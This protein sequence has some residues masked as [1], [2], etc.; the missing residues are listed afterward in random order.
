MLVKIDA[1]EL[2]CVRER[3]CNPLDP[4]AMARVLTGAAPGEVRGPLPAQLGAPF[5]SVH[6]RELRRPF[7]PRDVL[8]GIAAVAVEDHACALLR[9]QMAQSIEY[10][11][12]WFGEF[13]GG[14]V[15]DRRVP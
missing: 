14:L 13:V 9:G 1:D 5:D 7:D 4:G 3:C 12:R 15:G 10:F 2:I 11:E 8:Q 6:E